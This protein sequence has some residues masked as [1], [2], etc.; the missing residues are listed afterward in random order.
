VCRRKKSLTKNE[1]LRGRSDISRVFTGSRRESAASYTLL[2]RKN[3]LLRNRIL[4]ITEKGIKSAVIRNREKRISKEIY[5]SLK[6]MLK[7]GFDIV[8]ISRV[9]K[10][11]FAERLVEMNAL[12]VKADLMLQ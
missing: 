10:K 4:V 8:V 3:G 2:F 9:N 12:F 5:R 11:K 7:V 6:E 1:I